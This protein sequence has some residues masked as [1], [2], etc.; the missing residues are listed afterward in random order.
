M[1]RTESV[2]LNIIMMEMEVVHKHR[3]THAFAAGSV[4]LPSDS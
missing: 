4:E 2:M 1:K 3:C